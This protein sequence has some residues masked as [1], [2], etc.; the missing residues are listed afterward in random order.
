MAGVKAKSGRRKKLG[1]VY[2]LGRY[3]FVPGLDPPELEAVLRAIAGA[4]DASRRRDIIK[5]ALLSGANEARQA[6]T[7]VES[8]LI[9]GIVE[10]MLADF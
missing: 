5:A 4:G 9:T 2:Y 7:T 10:D 1:R 3:R 8:T 6:A